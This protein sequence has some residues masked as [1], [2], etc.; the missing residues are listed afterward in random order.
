MSELELLQHDHKS[1]QS[2][3][4]MLQE[5]MDSVKNLE[6]VER[7]QMVMREKIAARNAECDKRVQF[8]N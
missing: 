8:L 5:Y 1:L 4:N 3:F 6:V 2:S 7:E